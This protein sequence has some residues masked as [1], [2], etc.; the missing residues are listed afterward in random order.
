MGFA[1]AFHHIA[2]LHQNRCFLSCKGVMGRE[3]L[4]SLSG[5]ESRRAYEGLISG[6]LTNYRVVRTSPEPLHLTF[7]ACSTI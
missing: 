3:G 5:D 2:V 7:M 1:C 6:E 4:H